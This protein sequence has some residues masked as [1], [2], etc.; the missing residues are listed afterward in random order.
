MKSNFYS[1]LASTWES[2]KD[3][4]TDLLFSHLLLCLVLK[5]EYLEPFSN[6]NKKSFLLPVFKPQDAT[7]VLFFTQFK[8]PIMAQ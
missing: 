6:K 1:C 3:N 7:H 2:I 4:K 8:R 5:Y